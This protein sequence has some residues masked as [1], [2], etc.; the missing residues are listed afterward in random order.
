MLNLVPAL[1][2]RTAAFSAAAGIAL[3]AAACL[4]PAPDRQGPTAPDLAPEAAG[5]DRAPSATVADRPTFTPYTVAPD[6]LNRTEIAAALAAEY[7]PLLRGAGVGG[8]VRV[9]FFID[10]TG[11]VQETRVQE[12]SGHA[13]LDE[14]AL[15]VAATM[16][17][18]AALNRDRPV[19]VW[20][21]FPITFEAGPEPGPADAIEPARDGDGPVFTPYALAPTIENRADV[22]AALEREYP[23]ELRDRGVGGTTKVWF[24]IDEEGRLTDTRISESSGHPAIDEAALEVAAA[25]R[26]TAARDNDG[27]AV[28]VWVSYPITFQVR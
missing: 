11:T 21:N 27:N 22:Q 20:V 13:A 15:R 24:H 12:S 9:W 7:P 5:A 14:A 23:A 10:E 16:R 26:F 25:M 19:P 4:A 1:T 3:L 8:T 2:V 18:T 17:F 6:V 28:A